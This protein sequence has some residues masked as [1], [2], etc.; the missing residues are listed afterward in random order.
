MCLICDVA[1]DTQ[2]YEFPGFVDPSRLQFETLEP[3]DRATLHHPS[4]GCLNEIYATAICGNDL[5][6]SVLYVVGVTATMSGQLAPLCLFIVGLV[7]YLFKS[8]YGEVRVLFDGI[9]FSF[10]S[11]HDHCIPP[12]SCLHEPEFSLFL[13]STDFLLL[14][15]T[16]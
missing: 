8:V 4:R 6:S 13:P 14:G 3:V 16:A 7:L 2:R 9:P 1:S 12:C 5:T 15:M 11:L 10:Q